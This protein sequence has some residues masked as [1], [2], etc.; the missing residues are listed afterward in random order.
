MLP[1]L[2]KAPVT[3]S[4]TSS[5][6]TPAWV[7]IM[8]ALRQVKVNRTRCAPTRFT[9]SSTPSVRPPGNGSTPGMRATFSGTN[10]WNGIAMYTERK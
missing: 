3:N 2:A 7:T 5:S 10:S 1:S 4:P 6:S 9:N 8:P